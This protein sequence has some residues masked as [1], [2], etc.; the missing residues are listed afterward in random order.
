MSC[1][2]GKLHCVVRAHACIGENQSRQPHSAQA[3]QCERRKAG[4]GRASR[5]IRRES[6]LCRS[7]APSSNPNRSRRCR[8][9]GMLGIAVSSAHASHAGEAGGLIEP[10][11]QKDD[12]ATRPS[13]RDTVDRVRVRA[14]QLTGGARRQDEEHDSAYRQHTMPH[15][16]RLAGTQGARRGPALENSGV[17]VRSGTPRRRCDGL[18]KGV[19]H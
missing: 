9:L 11:T 2:M 8:R 13:E 3:S 17:R 10:D 19:Q 14:A 1:L 12:T 4:C 7:T 5:T 15:L 18:Q 16:R 6:S